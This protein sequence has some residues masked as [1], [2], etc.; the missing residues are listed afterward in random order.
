[1]PHAVPLT[2][3]ME[4]RPGYRLRQIL[5]RGGFA[6]VW[7]AETDTG[8]SVALKFMHCDDGLAA[9][10]E[11]R[12]LEQIR[13]VYHHNLIKIFQ[14]WCIPGY[15]VIAMELA[16]GSLLDLF[17]AYQSEFNSPVLGEQ[18]CLHLIQ[19]AEA[20]DFMNRRQHMLDGHK[21]GF[22]HCDIKP[23]NLLLFE[24]DTVKVADFGLA[25][26]TGAMIRSHRRA[27]TL[28]YAAP[29]VFQGR[30]S[31]WTDQYALAV[32]YCFLRGGRFPFNDTPPKFEATYVRPAPDL[33]MLA[34][35]EHPVVLKALAP[36]PQARWPSCTE[37]ITRLSQLVM[38]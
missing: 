21:V 37:F 25:S 19:A 12:A 35:Q 5:G 33:S 3:G 22:Q 10:K 28:D 36:V 23:S 1:V 16:D 26:P 8:D 32:T 30:L 11:I 17:D 31:D 29:E 6:E 7:E 4:P 38:N 18:V 34:A 15:I 9:A 2:T 24:D 20:I 14:V 27:G 13:K